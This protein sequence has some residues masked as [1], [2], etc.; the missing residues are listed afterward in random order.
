[1]TGTHLPKVLGAGAEGF[2]KAANL[3]RP[4]RREMKMLSHI[5]GSNS[6][7][8]DRA[9]NRACYGSYCIPISR[10][11]MVPSNAPMIPNRM[12]VVNMA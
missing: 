3:Q 12:W 9:L 6:N 5:D 10:R 1:M 4:L 2:L 7:E 11:A 8:R